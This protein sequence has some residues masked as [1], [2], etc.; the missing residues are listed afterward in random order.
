MFPFLVVSSRARLNQ[1]E[2]VHVSPEGPVCI[3]KIYQK[4]W[5]EKY[6]SR[7]YK[8]PLCTLNPKS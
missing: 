4:N 6:E 8:F 1:S 2:D 3:Q 5:P 7:V